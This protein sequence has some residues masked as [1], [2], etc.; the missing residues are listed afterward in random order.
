MLAIRQSD[1]SL[2]V[3][4]DDDGGGLLPLGGRPDA[5]ASFAVA[6]ALFD[7]ADFAWAAGRLTSDV[8][9][10]LGP[11]GVRAFDA[12][13]PE[14]PAHSP[15]RVFP[16]GGYASMRG[17]WEPDAH[18]AIVDIGPIG[19]PVSGGHGHADLLS[20]Q[21]SIFGE[22][23][24]VDAGTFCYTADSGWRDFF[25]STAAHSTV[26]V[27]GASQAQ[28]AGSFGWR[29]Q[30]RV[31]LRE[32]HSTPEFDFLDAEHDGYAA[33]PEPVVHRRR[34]VFVKP[35][36]WILVDDLSGAGRHQI[37][38]TFQFAPL[39]VTLDAHPWARAETRGGRVL[40]ICP[41]P[42]APV[43]P[44]LKYGELSP[45]RGWISREYGQREPA[46][47]LIYS[48]AVALPWRMLTL[49]LPDR[50]LAAPPAVRAIYDESGR[51]E[52]VAFDRPRR[53]VRVDERAVSVER[54]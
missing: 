31:R 42:V 12:L 36:Y 38:L 37:D 21:C 17:G 19:C 35:G 53:V 7:R 1:G 3:I 47:M 9:W 24:L 22:P 16:S 34:V 23:C 25:R 27:D 44:A 14:P 39:T 4:G 30:P 8:L 6:A 49:L 2:P 52:G 26:V 46:P 11:S 50:R 45:V 41:F 33:L 13:R 18:H 40:W 43:Q 54:D 20:I 32:W 10:L 15:S 5:R 51:P 28:P 29:R 48:F